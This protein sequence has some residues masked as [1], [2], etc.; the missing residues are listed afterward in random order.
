M[1][2]LPSNDRSKKKKKIEDREGWH[3]PPCSSLVLFRLPDILHPLWEPWRS[4]LLDWAWRPSFRVHRSV[5][6]LIFDGCHYSWLLLDKFERRGN[7]RGVLTCFGW[8]IGRREFLWGKIP[9]GVGAW[10]ITINNYSSTLGR[11]TCKIDSISTTD[12]EEH[13]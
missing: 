3:I 10:G 12:Y 11:V 7:C 2:H 13:G 8:C 4:G 1:Y 9:G 5:S 6:V